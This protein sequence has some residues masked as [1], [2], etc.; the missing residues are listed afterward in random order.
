LWPVPRLAAGSH[1][2]PDLRALTYSTFGATCARIRK[3][4]SGNDL[5]KMKP[6][7][8][9]AVCGVSLQP[10]VTLRDTVGRLPYIHRRDFGAWSAIDLMAAEASRSS[11]RPHASSVRG[12]RRER[13]PVVR[14]GECRHRRRIRAQGTYA[15][16]PAGV[17]GL[18]AI[19]PG[20]CRMQRRNAPGRDLHVRESRNETSVHRAGDARVRAREVG[21]RVFAGIVGA[22]RS[23]PIVR[24]RRG[25]GTASAPTTPTSSAPSATHAR[26]LHRHRHRHI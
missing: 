17:V 25:H 26:S 10:G 9:P 16:C 1:R 24:H 4:C 2:G 21:C 14:T 8:L 11:P 22:Q 7:R 12:A 18:W 23:E 3:W 6:R 19:R 13:R 20:C 5:W 15:R